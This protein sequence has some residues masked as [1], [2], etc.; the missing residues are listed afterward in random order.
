MR[1]SICSDGKPSA[2]LNGINT[3]SR[4]SKQELGTA[5]CTTPPSGTMPLP[6][7]GNLGVDS[8]ILSLRAS[9]ASHSALQEKDSQRTTR[10]TD[11]LPQ[12]ES[13]AK[14][15]HKSHGWKMYPDLFQNHTSTPFSGNFP[16]QG[17]IS[18]GVAFRR[19]RLARTTR[20][21]DSGYWLST[22][23]AWDGQRGPAK[24]YKPSSPKQSDRSLVT[25]A[26]K[27][28]MFPTPKAAR[29]TYQMS[30]GKKRYTLMGMALHPE[31]WPTPTVDDADNSTLPPSQK[32][33]NN[34][35]G[36]LMREG[37][38]A[39]G[40]L[41]PNWVEWLMGWPIGW[42]DLEPLETD[43]F[44]QWLEKHGTH[45]DQDTQESR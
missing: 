35:P 24:E 4:V 2:T 27:G 17:S 13:F 36:T 34:L 9:R 38:P 22:P 43:R 6:S 12:Y 1:P 29:G 18:N 42:T 11:G 30:G 15:D 39:G 31:R 26:K 32:E 8:W 10:E 41:N 40:Q 25:F 45:C 21:T 33:R 14:Y 3:Q 37:Q 44:R 16:K 7:T 20:G 28:S 5:T 19:P 23:S